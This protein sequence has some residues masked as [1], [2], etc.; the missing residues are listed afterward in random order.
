MRLKNYLCLNLAEELDF[1]IVMPTSM[2]SLLLLL[3]VKNAQDISMF[4]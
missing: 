1:F 3:F 4:A 2:A